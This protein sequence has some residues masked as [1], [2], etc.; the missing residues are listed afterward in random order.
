MGHSFSSARDVLDR[1]TMLTEYAAAAAN[2]Y[3]NADGADIFNT[4]DRMP[5]YAPNAGIAR[6]VRFLTS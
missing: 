6:Q 4:I 5:F 3:F 2:V 1:L